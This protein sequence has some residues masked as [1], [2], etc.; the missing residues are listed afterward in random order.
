MITLS[1]RIAG[2]CIIL[3][4]LACSPR[5]EPKPESNPKEIAVTS[6]PTP[7]EDAE[8]VLASFEEYR[9]AL[10]SKDG[11]NAVLHVDGDTI[12]Y[13]EDMRKA[14]LHSPRSDVEALGL[15]DRLMV[16][17]LRLRVPKVELEGM[18][19]TSMFV[20]AVDNGWIGAESV[21]RLQLGSPKPVGDT[22]RAPVMSNGQET[23][24]KALFNRE[25]GEWKV[26]LP[27]LSA[28]AEPA[29]KHLAEQSGYEENEF[30]FLL[31]QQVTG[32]RPTE[33]VWEPMVS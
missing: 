17:M 14:A 24:M 31:L 16:L 20:Y 30:L 32:K 11:G 21:Q 3:L 25:T 29:F 8:A 23:P 2:I 18:D 1:V 19:G 26:N 15:M 12:H 13:Y 4:S 10:L 6:P 27:S 7:E 22:A 9:Q 5:N 28:L 33:D